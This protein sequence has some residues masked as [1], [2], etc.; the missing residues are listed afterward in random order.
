MTP[1][2]CAI[3]TRKSSE[4]GLEQEFNSLDAQREAC[5]AYILSQRHEGW[6]ELPDAY[7][8]GGISGGTME[9][10]GLKRL[11][12]D[13]EAGRIDVVVVYK[14]DRLTRSLPDFAKIVE[15]FD[16]RDVV[17]PPKINGVQQ[18]N[19]LGMI[20]DDLRP[21]FPPAVWR[22]R[23]LI[24]ALRSLFLQIHFHGKLVRR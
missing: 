3:Y 13:I 19:F 21:N 12:S 23:R 10:P 9:R 2:R 24:L 5:A 8:D 18:W 17:I 6:R 16:A 14:V 1:Q 7:D 4:E 22:I 20:T 11:L 15:I